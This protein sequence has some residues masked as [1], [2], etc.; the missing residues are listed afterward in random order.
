[1]R[2]AVVARNQRRGP[3]LARR[4]RSQRRAAARAAAA[5]RRALRARQRRGGE[6]QSLWLAGGSLRQR[7]GGPDARR[8]VPEIAEVERLAHVAQA[9]TAQ[10]FFRGGSHVAGRDENP[11]LQ[12]ALLR[13]HLFHQQAAAVRGARVDENQIVPARSSELE[14]VLRALGDF[15]AV[16]LAREQRLHHAAHGG[17][18]VHE[19]NRAAH[20]GRLGRGG[21][22]AAP[23]R[24]GARRIGRGRRQRDD[25][26][27][28]ARAAGARRAL[29][30]QMAA[31]RFHDR[32]ADR[33]SQTG[34]LTRLLGREERR[35]Q[36]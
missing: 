29:E 21:G 6:P 11:L 31:V 12:V 22:G 36:L 16:S 3:Q 8:F 19:E 35:E 20:G 5:R 13:Q 34:A 7:G 33:Q 2:R 10:R 23:R 4:A 26:R 1:Q 27:G 17:I 18:V 30:H 9:E 24:R 28:A 25:E 32:V 14:R 15:H